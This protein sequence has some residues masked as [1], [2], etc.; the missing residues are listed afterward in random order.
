V[1]RLRNE[2]D[3]AIFDCNEALKLRP[4]LP[5]ALATR[6]AAYR[7]KGDFATALRDLDQAIRL[8]KSNQFARDQQ[9]LAEQRRK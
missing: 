6:G 1:Y 4:S 7:Q 2:Y 5:M 3:R 8:D 9:R